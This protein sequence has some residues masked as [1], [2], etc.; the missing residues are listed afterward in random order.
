MQLIQSEIRQEK[1]AVRLFSAKPE[2][3]FFSATG[4]DTLTLA[5]AQLLIPKIKARNITLLLEDGDSIDLLKE[6]AEALVKNPKIIT[7]TAHYQGEFNP[8][9]AQVLGSTVGSQE[10]KSLHF[11]QSD[12]HT[13]PVMEEVKTEL[14]TEVATDSPVVVAAAT[15]STLAL[16]PAPT[17]AP[18]SKKKVGQ[19]QRL[20]VRD[21][22]MALLQNNEEYRRFISRIMDQIRFSLSRTLKALRRRLPL[23]LGGL[24]E[25]SIGKAMRLRI[26][27]YQ[28]KRYRQVLGLKREDVSETTVDTAF[29]GLRTAWHIK[30]IPHPEHHRLTQLNKHTESL[31]KSY[32]RVLAR[33]AKEQPGNRVR[34]QEKI[35]A[36]EKQRELALVKQAIHYRLAAFKAQ[37]YHTV[38]G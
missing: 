32:Q 7:V 29:N 21:P 11:T 20:T 16:I 37:Q 9:I 15:Q 4:V 28:G 34:L 2:A 23:V 18:A 10:N 24:S 12:T 3:Q 1:R 27:S 17:K 30:R 25:D 13:V 22:A 8:E 6:V 14:T 33:L 26:E 38:L 5:N 19:E 31:Y 36:S 35:E